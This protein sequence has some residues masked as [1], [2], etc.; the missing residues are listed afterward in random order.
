VALL[1]RHLV[2]VVKRC[3]F[4]PQSLT[5]AAG[6]RPQQAMQKKY[7]KPHSCLGQANVTSTPDYDF[8]TGVDPSPDWRRDIAQLYAKSESGVIGGICFHSGSLVGR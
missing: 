1:S 8:K 5:I 7:L 3:D 4:N 6:S 2:T